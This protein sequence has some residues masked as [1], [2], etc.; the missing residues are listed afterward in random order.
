MTLTQTAIL[1]KQIILVS[2]ITLVLGLTSFI[3]YKIWYAYY[4]AHL[5]PVEEKPDA[6]FGLLP[7]LDFPKGNVSTSNFSYSLD[8]TT[9][10]LPKIGVD[11]GFEKIIKVYFV[12]QTFATL[13]SAD[14]SQSLAEKFS[15]TAQPEVLSETKYKFRDK[16][17]TLQV[18]LDNGNFSYTNEATISAQPSLDSDNKD[19]DNKLVSDFENILSNLGVLKDD[20]KNGRTKVT[21]L[22]T[23]GTETVLVSLWPAP[24][25]KKSIFSTD[26]SKSLVSA[27]VVGGANI[28]ENYL[29]LNFTYYPIETS[30]FAT[31]P[32]KTAETAFDDLK[33]GKG[34]VVVEPDKP[35]VSITSVYLGY[36]L[37]ENYNPYLQPIFV[38][39][40]PNFVA[41]VDAISDQFKSGATQN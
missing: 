24:I 23:N 31:Y 8:T 9:G 28:L 13:L 41:Y 11:P 33:Q 12:T 32:T 3:G 15:I 39:E 22:K 7:S 35:K 36:Y 30:T 21:H 40:G 18:N 2:S 29:S 17:K 25:D 1:V 27:T 16:E 34:V 5:P 26:S 37:A 20:L 38:F 19:S 6:K 10:G 4:L 14:R